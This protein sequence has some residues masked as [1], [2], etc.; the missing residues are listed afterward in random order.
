[1]RSRLLS[2]KCLVLNSTDFRQLFSKIV[3]A[4]IIY[5]VNLNYFVIFLCWN[6]RLPTL[7]NLSTNCLRIHMHV[8]SVS[9]KNN[10]L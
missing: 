7:T 3:E 10:L 6:L 1:M 5:L 2:I 9:D 4:L 8:V